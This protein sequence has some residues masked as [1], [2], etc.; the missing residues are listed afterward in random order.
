MSPFFTINFRRATYEQSLA[1][2]RR[3]VFLLA[4]WLTYGGVLVILLGLFALNCAVTTRRTA[5]LE[6]R[7][8]RLQSARA[9]APELR[10]DPADVELV[11]RVSG[12][13][14][15]WRDK[16]ARL[17]A[18]LP[19]NAKLTSLAV[20]PDRASAPLDQRRMVMAGNLRTPDGRDRLESV[21]GLVEALR[22]D[23]VFSRGYQ[24]VKLVS[25]RVPDSEGPPIVEF[26]VEC[27]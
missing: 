13:P 6:R 15:F 16:L 22:A 1:R 24:N 8:Q 27:R 14:G 23:S 9:A 3:R 25:S 26:V 10:L 11:Q 12:S 20:N 5:A 17:S 7:I 4:A 18:I 2:A 19:P 21:V